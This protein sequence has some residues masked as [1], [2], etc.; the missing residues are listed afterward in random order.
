MVPL[1]NRVTPFGDIVA[2]QGRGLMMGNRGILHDDHRRIVRA[3][4]TRRWIACVLSF[5]G[6]RRT[7][8]TPHTYTELFF[9]DEA[10]ALSAG[11]RPCAE[12][13]R[14][15]YRR[16]RSLWEKCHGRVDTVDSIDAVLH[17]ERGGGRKKQTY[18]AK[19]FDLPD[20]TY[21]VV[22]GDALLVWGGEL[23]VWSD[24]GYRERRTRVALDRVE[25]LTP[26]SIVAVLSA[27]YRPGVYPTAFTTC[28]EPMSAATEE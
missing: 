9:L 2:L 18:Y 5:R 6:I 23:L 20:G 12:C 3:S 4:Q 1:Q 11:H 13:R 21:I 10:T 26:R 19:L 27:G 28:G 14:D 22:D 15:D 17:T 7:V 16:F 8:M 25:V 24:A